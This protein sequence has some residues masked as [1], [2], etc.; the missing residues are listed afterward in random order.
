[1][2]QIV[3]S[4]IQK[5]PNNF[6]KIIKLK[7][8]EIFKKLNELGGEKIS[9][10]IYRYF[11]P[12]FN[13]KCKECGKDVKFES[14]NK[15]YRLFCSNKCQVK[16]SYTKQLIK[17]S[18]LN[19]YGVEN[20][21]QLDSIKDKKEKTFLDRY[22]IKCPFNSEEVKQ[23]ARDGC[24]KY[25]PCK[26]QKWTKVIKNNFV[27]EC[28]NGGRLGKDIIPLF[29]Y[30]T[31]TSVKDRNLQ[32]KCK[33]CDYMFKSHL[34][35]GIIPQCKRCNGLSKYEDELI[36][37]VK[38]L[39]NFE[40]C[41]NIFNIIP[42]GELDIYLPQ[43]K[44]AI[45]FNGIY[46]HSIYKKK[47]NYHLIKTKKC[48]TLGIKLIHIFEDKWLND[49][50][51]IKTIIKNIIQNDITIENIIIE[52]ECGKTM[53]DRNYYNKLFIPSNYDLITETEPIL[54]IVG[55][56]QYYDCG[57]LEIRKK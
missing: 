25:N 27:N 18:F 57:E 51:N 17:Q 33:K 50:E 26:I 23:K 1:M 13:N 20:I 6:Q 28:L 45:E 5:Y 31:F 34:M 54:N 47:K 14:F 32:F 52:N 24:K 49:M 39:G 22:G 55:N 46:W 19:K 21:S 16:S 53:I 43:L 35:W 37:Y 44:I 9:E 56:L 4:L 3:E 7:Y 11:N 36:E 30:D 38:T 29:N 8:P 40:I 2:K 12:D 42:Y 48:E 15:G 41:K 10:N